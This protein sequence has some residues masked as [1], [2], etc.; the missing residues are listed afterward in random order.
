MLRK[1]KPRGTVEMAWRCFGD[2]P[3]GGRNHGHGAMAISF[4]QMLVVISM[5]LYFYKWL[6]LVLITLEKGRNCGLLHEM[7]SLR[8]SP[9]SHGQ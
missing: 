1:P 3:L 9:G 8:P 5:G 7:Y 2:A 4:F 6:S